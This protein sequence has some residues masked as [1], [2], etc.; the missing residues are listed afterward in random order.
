MVV[1]ASSAPA[2]LQVPVGGSVVTLQNSIACRGNSND[3]VG[4][5]TPPRQ[6][7][8]PKAEYPEKER[9]AR[10]EGIVTLSVTVGSDGEPRDIWVL[11]TLGPDFDKAAIDS[12]KQWKFSP[13]TKD[14]KAVAVRIAVAVDFVLHARPAPKPHRD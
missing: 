10:R 6:T 9:K 3:V 11:S 8:A 14:G 13:A 7:R 5:V 12:L 4:C 1:K 2:N